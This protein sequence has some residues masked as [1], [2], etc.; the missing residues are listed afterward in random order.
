MQN[1]EKAQIR[2]QIFLFW[3]GLSWFSLLFF[4]SIN[5]KHS[6]R[7]I[8]RY[9]FK[10]KWFK[11]S[12]W[13]FPQFFLMFFFS[14]QMIDQLLIQRI[15]NT[16]HTI[17]DQI[18][19][20]FKTRMCFNTIDKFLLEKDQIEFVDNMID[21]NPIL[22]LFGVFLILFCWLVTVKRDMST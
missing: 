21:H 8:S 1:L 13:H 17:T 6:I 22:P 4:F 11:K 12:F 14:I 16:F 7:I 5:H 3:E 19:K 9:E 18:S 10:K 20:M 2:M 15:C